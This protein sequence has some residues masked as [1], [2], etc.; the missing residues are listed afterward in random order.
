M[1]YWNRAAEELYGFTR[2]EALGQVTHRLLGTRR[3]DGLDAP[4]FEAR[5][6]EEGAWRGR[7]SHRAKDGREVVVDSRHVLM[8]GSTRASSPCW[9]RAA[10]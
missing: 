9:S 5:L 4:T 10:T 1:T 3:G 7:L 8:P 6:R 2:Q